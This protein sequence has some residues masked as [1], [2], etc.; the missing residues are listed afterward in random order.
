MALGTVRILGGDK[1]GNNTSGGNW[2]PAVQVTTGAARLMKLVVYV[3]NATAAARWIWLCDNAAGTPSTAVDPVP[4]ACPQGA[5]VTLD[6]ADGGKLFVNG[7]YMIVSTVEPTGPTAQPTEGANNDA[8]V[9]W[10][11]WLKP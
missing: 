3:P 8:K 5:T 10:E 7:I 4:L 11:Y 6:F 2:V 9:E 1:T